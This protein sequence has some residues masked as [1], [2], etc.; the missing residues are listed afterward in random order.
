MTRPCAAFLTL[1]A[2]A[3]CGETPKAPPLGP[4][5]IRERWVYFPLDLREE[6]NVAKLE[7]VMRRAAKAG[8]NTILLEDGNFGKLPLMNAAYFRNIDRVK[9]AARETGMAIVPGLFQVGHSESLLAQD[10]NLA[11]G[12]PVRDALFVI[13][14]GAA[15]LE[16]DP[17]VSLKARWDFRD[18]A[19]SP[20]MVV[21]DP[22]G[23]YARLRQK[24]AVRPFR[25]YHVSVRVRTRDFRGV[26]RVF[27]VGA[28]RMLNY[29]YLGAKPT[30]DWTV[31][32]AFFNS[33]E[34]AQ[35]DLYLGCWDGDTGELAWA[36]PKIEEIG[37]YNLIRRDGA[38][39]TVR[40]EDGHLLAE[41]RDY[42]AVSDP[43]LVDVAAARDHDTWHEPPAIRTKLPEGTRLR[44]SYYHAISMPD[45]G[46]TMICPSEPRTWEILR[47]QARRLQDLF[48]PKAFLLSFDEIRVLNWDE[49]CRRR[50]R[51]PAQIVAESAQKAIRILREVNPGS[52]IY[53]WN[54]VFDPFHNAHDHYCL[55]NGD[56][57]GTWEGLDRDVIIANWYF[58]R[59]EENLPW[60]AARG[61]RTLIAGYYD[62][63]PERARD[64]ME[65]ARK[66]PGT[67]GI[68]Y[69]SWF[70]KYEDLETFAGHVNAIR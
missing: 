10:P 47:D 49:S 31:H 2:L 69:T 12:L 25:Q 38:P 1:L 44:V 5:Q 66:Y 16:P 63:H 61:H 50:G 40:T 59:R 48:S 62:K 41:G 70:D 58:D 20:E 33:L 37:L 13:R 3:G 51:T 24:V 64:W 55:V 53:A 57:T 27:T 18:P 35:V 68:M 8:Y 30:Q 60:W 65:S 46:Q 39:L 22:R 6:K 26:P 17:P 19:V 11:E 43:G 34:A 56:L 32:H 4:L 9:A 36:D 28:G 67:I 23:R 29:R 15:R 45:H 42:D 52:E 54:D 14:G 21:T 7:G